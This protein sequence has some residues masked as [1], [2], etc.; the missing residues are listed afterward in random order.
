MSPVD[1]SRGISF[2]F[3]ALHGPDW[4]EARWLVMITGSNL[5]SIYEHLCLSKQRFIRIGENGYDPGEGNVPLP[6]GGAPHVISVTV[7]ELPKKG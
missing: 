5:R 7:T 1:P 6:T 4:K 3:E 2:V